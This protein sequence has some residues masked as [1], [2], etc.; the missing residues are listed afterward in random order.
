MKSFVFQALLK[1]FLA[2]LFFLA[3]GGG[4][5]FVGF[6]DVAVQG[7]R[8][9][10]GVRLEVTRTHFWGLLRLSDHLEGVTSVG[11]ETR[12]SGS[13]TKRR[14]VSNVVVRSPT[15]SMS[16]FTGDSNVDE[17]LKRTAT[18][19]ISAFLAD[20]KAK[21]FTETFNTANVFGYVGMPFLLIGI[22]GVFGWPF[23]IVRQLRGR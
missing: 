19:R 14:T 5:V 23:T 3:F 7:R 13:G 8:T 20:D 6:Q 11:I 12:R 4:F 18:E 10:A 9:S 15:D 22:S 21:G 2:L 17:E 1:P 16:L